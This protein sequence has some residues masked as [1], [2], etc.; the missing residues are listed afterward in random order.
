[1]RANGGTAVNLIHFSMIVFN[2]RSV[3]GTNVYEIVYQKW[4]TNAAGGTYPLE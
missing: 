2:I 4:A 3:Q 1:M